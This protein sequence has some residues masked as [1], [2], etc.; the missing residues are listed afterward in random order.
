MYNLQAV[1]ASHATLSGLARGVESAVVVPLAQGISLLAMTDALFDEINVE[2]APRPGRFWKLPAGFDRTLAD[3]SV[4]G[5]V[6]YLE[7]EYFGGAGSQCAQVWDRGRIAL[8]PLEL[9]EGEPHPG[10]GSP[11]AR[12]LRRLGVDKA[13][14]HDEFDAVGLGRCRDTDDWLGLCD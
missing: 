4:A 6:A 12:A 13:G 5:P 7:A 8:G 11:I 2:R 1:V 9:A 14:H 3:R 10:G